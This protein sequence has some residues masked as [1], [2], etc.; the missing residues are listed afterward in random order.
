MS[1]SCRIL[2]II[3]LPIETVRMLLVPVLQADTA[4]TITS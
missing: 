2:A 3:I 4:P 1:V